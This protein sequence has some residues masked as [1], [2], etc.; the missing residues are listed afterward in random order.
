MLPLLLL[1]SLLFDAD[2]DAAKLGDREY[3]VREAATRRLKAAGWAALPSL[4]RTPP[5]N[6]EAAARV[7]MLTES[8]PQIDRVLVRWAASLSPDAVAA[9]APPIC[10]WI[11][12]HGGCGTVP[13]VRDDGSVIDCRPSGDLWKWSQQPTLVRGSVSGDFSVV[14]EG[15]LRR[16]RQQAVAAA[17]SLVT[18]AAVGP[19]PS[20]LQEIPR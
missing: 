16:P 10:N 13:L 8:L 18:L 1:L 7:E 17:T 15:W 3:A 11:A 2:A 4:T 14:V 6:A 12:T 9:V 19:T 5:A 20:A